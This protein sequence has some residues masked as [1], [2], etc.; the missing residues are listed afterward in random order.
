MYHE[1]RL[2][3][4]EYNAI[5]M[6]GVLDMTKEEFSKHA[7]PI[8]RMIGK[9]VMNYTKK[10]VGKFAR[11][12]ALPAAVGAGSLGVGFTA[13]SSL[14]KKRPNQVII[15]QSSYDTLSSVNDITNTL[16]QNGFISDGMYNA[17][18]TLC[19]NE[20]TANMVV[21]FMNA[22]FEKEAS[23]IDVLLDFQ[24]GQHNI[25]NAIS[26]LTM[27]KRIPALDI[28]SGVSKST[29]DL[30]GSAKDVTDVIKNIKELRKKPNQLLETAKKLWL[31]LSIGGATTAVAAQNIVEPTVNA[32]KINNSFRKMQEMNPSLAEEDQN[33]VKQYFN[34]VKTFSPKSASNP[35]VAGA[36]VNKMMQFGGVDHKL[37]QD[38]SS[39]E[40]GL[41]RPKI[42]DTV[43]DS[44]AQQ[45]IKS[46]IEM[47][48]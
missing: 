23:L 34:V 20:K 5:K 2:T 38:L 16:A 44:A 26:D 37:V 18:E 41:Q 25:M 8:M 3:Q 31:P 40:S 17:I 14:G 32:L 9:G 29:H 12:W 30:T 46:T 42:M 39:I 35:L 48:K 27:K 15:K 33:T 7:G 1:G 47:P 21:D 10:Q 45:L 28:I 13:M 4:D 43:R 22:D 19:T 6:A 36:L 11:K 24:K